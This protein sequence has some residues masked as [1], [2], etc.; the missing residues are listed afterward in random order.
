[1]SETSRMTSNGLI[2]NQSFLLGFSRL[3]ASSYSTPSCWALPNT[4]HSSQSG[5]T[6]TY[7][8]L[9]N[10]SHEFSKCNFKD[11][12]N[13]LPGRSDLLSHHSCTPHITPSS[14]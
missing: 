9:V 7:S 3:L 11:N 13:N 8:A 10:S 2:N 14:Q 5:V 6:I 12:I 1:M 4:C